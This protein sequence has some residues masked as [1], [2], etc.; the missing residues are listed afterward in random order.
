MSK[1]VSKVLPKRSNGERGYGPGCRR[2]SRGA[3]GSVGPVEAARWA[4]LDA[5]TWRRVLR[6]KPHDAR[7]VLGLGLCASCYGFIDDPRHVSIGA[8]ANRPQSRV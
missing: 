2:G 3:S 5:S 1:R 7:M 8:Y 4:K 6:D